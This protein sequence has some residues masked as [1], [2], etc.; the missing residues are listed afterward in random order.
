MA[1]T[2]S[3]LRTQNLKDSTAASETAE[4]KKP[5][6]SVAKPAAEKASDK[7]DNSAKQPVLA[8]APRANVAAGGSATLRHN[9]EAQLESGRIGN[10]PAVAKL[11]LT[12]YPNKAKTVSRAAERFLMPASIMDTELRKA[13]TREQAIDI[14]GTSEFRRRVFTLEGG[15]GLYHGR[16]DEEM[17][18]QFDAIK[19]I[20]DKIGAYTYFIQMKKNAADA[21]APEA[22]VK[23]Y[24]KKI[25]DARAE[26]GKLIDENWTLNDKGQFPGMK[27]L[28]RDVRHAEFDSYKDDRKLIQ[29]AIK[30]EAKDVEETEY[31]MNNL[32]EGIHE[33]RRD[34][35]KVT[36][37]TEFGNGLF[38]H[39]AAI[40]PI[41]D[42]ILKDP[43][44][45]SKYM[46][47][48][49]ADREK[50]PIVVSKSLYA[51]L[52]KTVLD[53]GAIK[54]RGEAIHGLRDALLES[55]QATSA[56]DAE[57][58]AIALLK[59]TPEQADLKGSASKIYEAMKSEGWLKQLRKQLTE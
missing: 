55:K 6:L 30:K 7:V 35:R 52:Q 45:S 16:L 44:A 50:D 54:D 51:K 47:M 56:A 8:E 5:E 49:P 46:N 34:L 15:L 21:G 4:A 22:T 53:L 38:Q 43:V 42:A 28:V 58:Q 10:H 48:D 9:I 25:A 1:T 2:I 31:D 18:A 23:L 24:D 57:K 19:E 14:L 59:Y 13:T 33:L 12:Y 39:D 20:E 17:D 36:T 29:K 32:E 3:S 37:F 40:A 11:L 26:L 27:A 41:D